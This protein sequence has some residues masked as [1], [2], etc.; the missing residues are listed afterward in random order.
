MVVANVVDLVRRDREAVFA[1]F[2]LWSLVHYERDALHDV[3]HVCEVAF[4]VAVVE[5]LYRVAFD[6]F[7][8][9]GEVCHVRSS[10]G[11]VDGEEPKSRGGYVVELG[12][13][14]G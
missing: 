14:V 13:C 11:A 2:L 8:G 1:G 5:N 10:C 12:V 9:E 3:V 4:A 6:E 7:V